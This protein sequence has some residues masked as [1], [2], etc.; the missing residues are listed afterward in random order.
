MEDLLK[1]LKKL[2]KLCD[3]LIELLVKVLIV[4][5]LLQILTR[6]GMGR[7]PLFLIKIVSQVFYKNN[8]KRNIH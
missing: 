8:E 4:L 2:N 3:Q 1:Q 6:Q 7:K 5:T